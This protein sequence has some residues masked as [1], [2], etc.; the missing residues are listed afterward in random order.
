MKIKWETVVRDDKRLR[1]AKGFPNSVLIDTISFCNLR[2]SMCGHKNIK[3]KP[4]KMEERLVYKILDEIA[5]KKPECRTWMTFFGEALILKDALIEYIKYAKEKGL[6]DVVFNTNGQLLTKDLSRKLLEAGLDGIYVGIDAFSAPTYEK[7]RVG[8]N[9]AKVV[10]NIN[11]FLEVE[12]ELGIKP[13]RMY[14]QLVEMPENKDQID[15]FTDYWTERGAVVK[16]RPKVS[17]AGVVPAANLNPHTERFPC[18]WVMQ[19]ISIL[20]NG[21]VALCAVDMEGAFNG[22]SAVQS[23]IAELWE[24][25]PLKGVRQI[26]LK[27][28]WGKLPE[29][30]RKCLDWQSACAVFKTK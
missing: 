16:I 13:T 25:G 6:K 15:A 14:V 11:D 23:S 1:E 10:K 19:N 20:D 2:C 24:K 29:L 22:G 4:A 18:Y 17:W 7:L 27:G 9:Y 8:G 21:Q 12:K 28:D 30:C 26:H 3:R 5:A